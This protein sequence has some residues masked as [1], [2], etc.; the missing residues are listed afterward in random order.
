MTTRLLLLPDEQTLLWL[1][2]DLT[3][4]ALIESVRR[5]KWYPP[6]PY[7]GRLAAHCALLFDRLVIITLQPPAAPPADSAED[8]YHRPLPAVPSL[9]PR[10]RQ[11]LELLAE[12]LTAKEMAGRLG[13]SLRQVRRHLAGLRQR[14]NSATLAQ[15]IGRAVSLGLLDES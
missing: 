9:T 12:G 14:F 13:L 7:G 2:S 15:S 4:T 11:V 5:G 3:P 1:E 10:Q 6:D 8:G